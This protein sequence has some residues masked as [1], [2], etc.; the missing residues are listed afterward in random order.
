MSILNM[1]FQLAREERGK[2][3]GAMRK[4]HF[5]C[6][7]C[8]MIKHYSICKIPCQKLSYQTVAPLLLPQENEISLCNWKMY[9][10]FS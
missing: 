3:G 10:C 7:M 6:Y 2:G 1:M 9:A 5:K 4:F 8:S